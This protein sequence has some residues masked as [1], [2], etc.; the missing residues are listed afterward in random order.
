MVKTNQPIAL[1]NGEKNGSMT[2][3]AN[4]KDTHEGRMGQMWLTIQLTLQG[5]RG[6]PLT[7][8]SSFL[9]GLVT[10]FFYNSNGRGEG[11]PIRILS[12]EI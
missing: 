8:V 6:T 2:P 4:P 3:L 1:T 11:Y 5:E 9:Q 7:G 12:E 10:R